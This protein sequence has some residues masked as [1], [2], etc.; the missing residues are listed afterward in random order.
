MLTIGLCLIEVLCGTLHVYHLILNTIP[1]QAHLQKD[2]FLAPCSCAMNECQDF[3][4]FINWWRTS[5]KLQS[6][7]DIW[8]T[9]MYV[10]FDRILHSIWKSNIIPLACGSPYSTFSLLRESILQRVKPCSGNTANSI[11]RVQ[12]SD[13]LKIFLYSFE[14]IIYQ[15]FPFS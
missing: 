7:Q 13:G 1:F 12:V 8:Q 2:K 10:Q 14:I 4:Q 6:V 3:L 9:Y 11:A 15:N 5:A